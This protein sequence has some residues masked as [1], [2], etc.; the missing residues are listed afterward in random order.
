MDSLFETARANKLITEPANDLYDLWQSLGKTEPPDGPSTDY[1]GIA[2]A[3]LNDRELEGLL[4]GL[5]DFEAEIQAQRYNTAL[6]QLFSL[7]GLR[8]TGGNIWNT[9]NHLWERLCDT[10]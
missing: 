3:W 10:M 9:S 8:H 6:E 2:P 7:T 1:R 5:S 4:E